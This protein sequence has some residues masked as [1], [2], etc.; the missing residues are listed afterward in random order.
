MQL[1]SYLCAKQIALYLYQR[2]TLQTQPAAIHRGPYILTWKR[3]ITKIGT[4]I[5][6]WC[7]FQGKRKGRRQFNSTGHKAHLLNLHK[8]SMLDGSWFCLPF[9][10]RLRKVKRTCRRKYIF[11]NYY[12]DINVRKCEYRSAIEKHFLLLFPL[13]FIIFTRFNTYLMLACAY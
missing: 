12:T 11:N 3:C 7:C 1:H 6:P 2:T 13:I 5:I 10:W 9:H 8:T 4:Y